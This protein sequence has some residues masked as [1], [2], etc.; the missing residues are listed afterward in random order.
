MKQSKV[1]SC[2]VRTMLK[3]GRVNAFTKHSVS[4]LYLVC[5]S[6]SASVKTSCT[7]ASKGKKLESWRGNGLNGE[8]WKRHRHELDKIGIFFFYCR[9]YAVRVNLL[10]QGFC[11]QGGFNVPTLLDETSFLF[12][13]TI[14]Y[15]EAAGRAV[16]LA[17]IF[18]T[19]QERA[20]ADSR[21]LMT[22]SG[23]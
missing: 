13:Q 11:V 5:K 16:P 19:R 12:V 2:N 23:P 20:L 7:V 18:I 10:T 15:V 4:L 17:G 22:R 1:Y 8:G 21:Q 3:K 6:A 14:H 9:V